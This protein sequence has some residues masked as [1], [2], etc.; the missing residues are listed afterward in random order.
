MAAQKVDQAPAET[1]ISE[2]KTVTNWKTFEKAGLV[3]S[4][5][6]CNGYRGTHPADQSCHSNL[7][8][9]TD[10]VKCHMDPMHGGGWFFF[11]LRQT[12][13]KGK[14]PIWR[15]LE[16]AGVEIQDLWC[17]H[18][19]STVQMTPRDL[20]AHLKPHTGANRVN[21]YL[22]TL[23]MTLSYGNPEQLEGED[24]GYE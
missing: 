21:I 17:P 4:R 24:E 19:R 18:C 15:E 11:R 14:N 9:T 13:A 20:Q 12:D 10:A 3:P 2:R 6:T 7:V 16:D 22:S 1:P 23:C 8:L 5:I